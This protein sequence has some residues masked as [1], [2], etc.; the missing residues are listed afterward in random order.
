MRG[1]GLINGRRHAPE[2]IAG[3]EGRK[4]GE[5]A[6]GRQKRWREV[7]REDRARSG[8]NAG[9]ERNADRPQLKQQRRRWLPRGSEN[10]KSLRHQHRKMVPKDFIPLFRTK[11][12]RF[13]VPTVL[14]ITKFF[15]NFDTNF[16]VIRIRIKFC[17]IICSVIYYLYKKAIYFP[18]IIN[19]I[20]RGSRK[21]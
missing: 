19:K 17:D 3:R 8:G 7:E 21:M 5:T 18:F 15:G 10:R 6:G 2:N 14:T 11:K 4:S 16:Q 1:E 12:V 13:F 9:R 20:L